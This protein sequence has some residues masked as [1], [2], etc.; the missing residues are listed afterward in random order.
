MGLRAVKTCKI[1]NGLAKVGCE[2]YSQT[3]S[4]GVKKLGKL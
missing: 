3:Q 2:N 1:M 4:N